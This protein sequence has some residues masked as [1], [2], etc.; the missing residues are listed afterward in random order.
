M[1]LFSLNHFSQLFD[2]LADPLVF[3]F[4]AYLVHYHSGRKRANL[5]QNLQAVLTKGASGLHNVHDHLGKPYNRS[6]LNGTVQFN[7]LNRLVLFV[8]EFGYLVA[9]RMSWL[10]ARRGFALS[11]PHTHMRQAPKPRSIT[12]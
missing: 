11:G 2:Q 10:D 6:K 8:I 3:H 4:H 12:S 5:L 9:T 7:D 1:R